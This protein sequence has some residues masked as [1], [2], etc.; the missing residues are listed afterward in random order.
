MHD[1][2][3]LKCVSLLQELDR[4]ICGRNGAHCNSVHREWKTQLQILHNGV[5]W[6]KPVSLA[7]LCDLLKDNAKEN[8]RLVFGNTGSGENS[9]FSNH[10]C[11]RKMRFCLA[12]VFYYNYGEESLF[13]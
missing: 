6:I 11:T 5:Q 10:S 3:L 1:F 13:L 4:K 8:Y 9:T 2:L 7:E 12:F